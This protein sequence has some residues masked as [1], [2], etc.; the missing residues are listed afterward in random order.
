MNI[1]L[2]DY[3]LEIRKS[4]ILDIDDI[5]VIEPL[6]FGR[7]HWSA[8]AFTNEFNSKYSTYKSALVNN[9]VIGYIGSWI[10]GDEGHITTLAVHPN[11]RK[12]HIADIL[13]YSL[14]IE[15]KSQNVKWLTLEVRVSNIPAINL[16]N[17]FRFKQL[18]IRK[19][20]YQDNNEDGLILWTENIQTKENDLLLEDILCQIKNKVS[21]TDKLQ[22]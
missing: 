6:C 17:K 11:Y 12:K 8:N 3:N 20:Y 18:G 21:N 22:Y 13:L 2:I 5:L 9:K 14:F 19:K 15:L 16:Y 10:I 7:H 1:N 4:K